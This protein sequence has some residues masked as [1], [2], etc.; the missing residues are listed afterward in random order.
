MQQETAQASGWLIN[1]FQ[2][3]VFLAGWSVAVVVYGLFWR[4]IS[5]SDP[6]PVRP[7]GPLGD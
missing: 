6:D 2:T 4:S 7:S 1:G 3:M 5:R